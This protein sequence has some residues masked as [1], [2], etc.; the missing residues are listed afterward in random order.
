MSEYRHLGLVETRTRKRACAHRTDQVVKQLVLAERS[1]QH[2]DW[3]L[4]SASGSVFHSLHRNLYPARFV[5]LSER[6]MWRAG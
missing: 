6:A 5:Y 1:R 3:P 2:S 4:A